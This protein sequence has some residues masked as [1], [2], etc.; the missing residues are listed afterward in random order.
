MTAPAR[1]TVALAAGLAA[2]A[3]AH[4]VFMYNGLEWHNAVEHH[5]MDLP[6]AL[7]LLAGAAPYGYLLA[8][9][10]MIC[11]VLAAARRK[12]S[13]T[14]VVSSITWLLAFSWALACIVLWKLPF[15]LL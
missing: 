15:A 13:A 6:L 1:W 3:S 12:D 10:S 7:K 2:L 14:I 5:D 8:T 11:L 9:L 4:F